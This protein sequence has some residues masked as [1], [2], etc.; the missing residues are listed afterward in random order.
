MFTLIV[1]HHFFFLPSFPSCD[2]LDG[3]CFV[4]KSKFV[5]VNFPA[6]GP[7]MQKKTLGWEPS[8]EKMTARDGA[9]KGDVTMFLKLEGGSNYKCVYRTSYKYVGILGT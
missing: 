9:L 7:V 5:G 1:N 8:T 4:H 3:E 6:N 2:S